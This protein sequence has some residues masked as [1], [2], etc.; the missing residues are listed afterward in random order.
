MAG[1][2]VFKFKLAGSGVFKF[3]WPDLEFLNSELAGSG[4]FLL[5]IGRIWS[6]FITSVAGSGVFLFPGG[7]PGGGGYFC[8]G[9]MGAET[10]LPENP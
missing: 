1:S 6:F 2:G 5:I 3:I 7:I 10:L 4:V 8:L 9:V